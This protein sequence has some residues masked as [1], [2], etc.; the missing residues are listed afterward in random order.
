MFYAKQQIFTM[1]AAWEYI[2]VK[3]CKVEM[4]VDTGADS[5][6]ISSKIWTEFSKSQM[7]RSDISKRMMVT[8]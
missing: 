3:K 5:T 6:V 4:Q 1:S 2:S 7:V 8:N